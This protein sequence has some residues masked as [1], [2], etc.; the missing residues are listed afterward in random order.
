MQRFGDETEGFTVERAAAGIR[1]KTWGFWG[2]DLATKFVPAVVAALR[3]TPSE[4]NLEIDVSEL[5]PLR[6]EGQRAF[7]QLLK[8]LT[9]SGSRD[10]VIRNSS[11]LTK[12]QMMRLVRDIGNPSHIRIE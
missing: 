11:A 10:V 1:L 9:T 7:E 6:D 4:G 5:R 8:Q 12:L 2:A 3:E